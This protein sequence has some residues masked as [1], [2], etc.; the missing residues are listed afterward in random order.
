M[1]CSYH[2]VS[3]EEAK[4][5]MDEEPNHVLLDVREEEEYITGHAAGAVLFPLGLINASTAAAAIPSK[6]T[7]VLVYCRSGRRSQQAVRQLMALGYD[8][9]YDLGGLIGW[10]YGMEW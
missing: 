9:V 10:P 8:R 6:D 4:Q 5:K 7:L 1:E 2:R 3:F